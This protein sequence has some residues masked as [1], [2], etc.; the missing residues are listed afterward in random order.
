MSVLDK[1]CY[2]WYCNSRLSVKSRPER[3]PS[4]VVKNP[5][6][7]DLHGPDSRF[8]IG[9]H[10]RRSWNATR[11]DVV[12]LGGGKLFLLEFFVD[13]RS[14]L[15]FIFDDDPWVPLGPA[16]WDPVKSDSK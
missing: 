8:G 5:T 13:F 3:R 6:V 1:H 14:T 12:V 11:C 7:A 16:S 10:P 9:V 2:D 4:S 15:D